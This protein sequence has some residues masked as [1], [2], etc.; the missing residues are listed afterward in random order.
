[1]SNAERLRRDAESIWRAGVEAVDSKRLVADVMRNTSSELVICGHAIPLSDLNRLVVVGTG[2]AGAGMAAGFEQAAGADL[3]RDRVTGWINVPADCVRSL[4]SIHLH[5]ARPA[6]VNEP[7]EEGARGA[8]EI[9]DLVTGLGENDVCVVLLSGGG[10]ALLPAPIPE[11]TLA[12]KQQV[13]RTLMHAGATIDELNCV[14]KQLSLLKGGGLARATSAGLLITLIISD[15]IGDPL[16]VIASGPTVADSSTAADALTILQKYAPGTTGVPRE[17]MEYLTQQAKESH[18]AEPIPATVHHHVIG[19]NATALTAAENRAVEL[20]YSVRSLG[21]ENEGEAR[22]VGRDLAEMC[23]SVRD[24]GNPLA[25]PA[26]LLSGGEPVVHL[27]ESDE[28]RKGGRNQEVAV[29]AIE[30]LWE[31]GFAG[32]LL[33]SGGTD[34]E[35][36]P[37]DAAGGIADA[38]VLSTAR[39]AGLCPAEFLAI[40]NTYPFLAQTGGLFKTGPTHTN[41]MDLRVAVIGE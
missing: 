25:A 4:Q 40:N 31:H 24:Q 32:M 18:Q 12:D 15:V 27:A 37:T 8:K 14:R 7:T 28:P 21:S 23:L 29:A 26:C 11:I 22:N 6:G 39:S 9:L 34:G 36:G 20:G 35:D 33:L 1:V 10:S 3:V 2:K 16:D 19:N 13:T 30:R 38:D 41:V 17:V 5:A